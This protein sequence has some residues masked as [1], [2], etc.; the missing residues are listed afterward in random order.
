[1]LIHMVHI[2]GIWLPYMSE[3]TM[4]AATWF[5]NRVCLEP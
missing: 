2:S 4:D 3:T 5:A 1:M